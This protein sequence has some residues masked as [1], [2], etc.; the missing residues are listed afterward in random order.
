MADV[1]NGTL[2]RT[3][4][5]VPESVPLARQ[6]LVRFSLLAGA[7]GGQAED[8]KLSVSEA[9]TNVVLHA[10]RGVE[11]VIHVR[12]SIAGDELWVLIGDDGAGLESQSDRPGLGVG[13]ALIAQTSDGLTI[14][15]RS[16]GGVELRM[17]FVLGPGGLDA[18][19]ARGSRF[20]ASSPA[21]PPFS[22]TT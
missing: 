9:L 19:Y 16:G 1:D 14:M 21:S 20:S 2:L 8:I 13:L 5:A 4:A 15:N 11:G 3:Y 10:Y 17:R 18:G 7:D 22:I 12:A 6:E